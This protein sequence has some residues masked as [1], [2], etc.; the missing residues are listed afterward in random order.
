M[1]E[2][3]IKNIIGILLII[4][5]IAGGL[6]VGGWEM[7]VKPILDACKHFDAGTLTGMIVGT[8]IL[9]CFF[10]TIVGSLIGYLGIFF[11]MF[12]MD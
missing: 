3:R 8:T 10:A 7:F 9:K 12:I 5:G 6:Y 11:G 2:S 4:A 1:S